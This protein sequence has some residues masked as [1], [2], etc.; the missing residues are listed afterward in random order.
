MAQ[1][2]FALMTNLGRAKEAAAI[3]D[4]T[5]V[6]ITHIAIG[7]GATVPSGGETALY[8]EIA[9]KTVSGHGTVSGA[10]NVAYFDIFL[11]AA[12]GPYT[13]REAGLIDQDGAL[14]A[15]ARYDPPINKPIPSSGQTVEGTVR[16]EVAFSNIANVTIVVDP[17]FNVPIQRLTRLP[18]LPVLSMTVTTPPASP[19]L[20]D[21]YLV[22]SGATGAWTGQGGK[23]AEYTAAGWGMIT[24]PNGHG[25]GLPDGRVFSRINGVY[26]EFLA[27]RVWVD[28]RKTPIAQLNALPW[29]SV[30]SITQTAP[31]AAPAEGDTYI[32]PS[33]ATGAWVG[34]TGQVAEW[35]EAAWR[36][37]VP[38][39]GHGVSLADGRLFKKIGGAYIEKLAL[40]VQT[41]KWTYAVA[42]GSANVITAALSPAPAALVAG[43]SVALQIT[44][45]NTS[46]VTLNVN[47]RG[48]KPVLNR[49]GA[50]LKSG[51]L[52]ANKI[53]GIT[54]D[55]AAF[56]LNSLTFSDLLEKPTLGSL[57]SMQVYNTAGTFSYNPTPGTKFVI[58][59][60]VG[61][62][63]A[64]GGV[65][66]VGAGNNAAGGG[67]ASGAHGRKLVLNPSPVTIVIG[68]G[69][70]PMAAGKGGNGGTTSFGSLMT[71][72]GGSGGGV[73]NGATVPSVRGT[74][75]NSSAPTGIDMGGHGGNG[76]FGFCLSPISVA[77]GLGGSSPYGMGG[78][79]IGIN[80]TSV[81]SGNSATGHG[82]GG[83]GAVGVNNG[84][85]AS[86]GSGSGGLL[87]I[88]EYAGG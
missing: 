19:V 1:N 28:N 24:P 51:D 9:R 20:G 38:S 85:T 31:P 18:W 11:A 40:D 78:A 74:T 76:M 37:S 25:I 50:A 10:A 72:P 8:H 46:A 13:I 22:P 65:V 26:V 83:S 52:I 36:Y 84:I 71:L 15:I 63:G 68:S 56:V 5:A 54:Y 7:D 75:A 21:T 79:P 17:T 41:G 35:Y 87:I 73:G 55:G 66:G 33:G 43:L 29:I 64:G 14:I 60:G 30:N 23:I 77:G 59:E 86:G 12:E 81:F 44:V 32:I 82:A 53:Y 70:A 39:N 4:G 49:S 88:W 45:N 47:G 69:G 3:A 6:V 58:V 16:L 67:G 34:K 48:A 42:A 57:L 62:G 2:S 80:D 27:S 61:G